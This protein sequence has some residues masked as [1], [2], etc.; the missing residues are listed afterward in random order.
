MARLALLIGAVP[1]RCTKG[2][3]VR[4][5]PGRWTL[6]IEHAIDSH[7][8]IRLES[9]EGWSIFKDGKVTISSLAIE[10]QRHRDVFIEFVER[11]TEAF[12]NVFADKVA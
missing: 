3:V 6:H 5:L 7:L 4:L 8:G 1:T 2:P 12:I 11:G 10:G 9:G